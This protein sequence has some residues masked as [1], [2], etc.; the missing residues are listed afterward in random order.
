MELI[1]SDYTQSPET[2]SFYKLLKTRVFARSFSV[3]WV[4]S[5]YIII[6]IITFFFQRDM[7]C[8]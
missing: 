3:Q 8:W 6:I 4:M 5:F 7:Q 2:D 1:A